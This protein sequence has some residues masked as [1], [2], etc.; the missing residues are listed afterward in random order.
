M[1]IYYKVEGN[2]PTLLPAHGLGSTG[3]DW[4]ELGNVN[5]L[6]DGY[7]AIMVE[8]PGHGKSDK[9]HD[10]LKQ[11]AMQGRPE[12][13]DPIRTVLDAGG[14]T[15]LSFWQSNMEVPVGMA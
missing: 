5:Q 12:A 8:G 3:E 1:R 15:W 6:I 7:R 11:N 10:P 14:V 4:C 9:L 13:D 2:G